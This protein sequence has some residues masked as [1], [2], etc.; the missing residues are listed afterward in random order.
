LTKKEIISEIEGRKLKLSNLD[1]CLYPD[2]GIVKAELIAYYLKVAPYILPFLR[3]RPL[4]LIR[5]PEGIEGHRFYSKN[6]PGWTP[7]WVESTQ[8]ST[9]DE[10]V[11]LLVNDV[12]SLIW[13]ANLAALELHPM[14]VSSR[15]PNRPDHF[16]F[17]LDPPESIDF[18]AVK[19]LAKRL[20]IFLE[21]YGYQP[22]LKTSGSKGLHIYVPIRS[23][24]EQ[25][26]VMECVKNLAKTYIETDKTTTLIMN[27]EKRQGKVLLDIYRNHKSQTCVAP[28]STR[29]K[30]GAPISAPLFWDEL[31]EIQTSQAYNIHT[32]FDKLDGR[33]DPWKKFRESETRLHTDNNI[34]AK[35]TRITKVDG[36]QEGDKFSFAHISL[37]PML[38]TLGQKAPS[39]EKYIFE[40]KWDGIRVIITKANSVVT[41]LSRNG[42]DLTDNFPIIREHISAQR[43]DSFIVDG[44]LVI[45]AEDGTPNF[46]K[47]VGRMH[48]KGRKAIHRS[49]QREKAAVYLF[50][51]LYFDGNDIRNLTIEKRRKWL[52]DNLHWG[53]HIKYSESFEDG[54]QLLAAIKAQ[55][56]EG[57]MCKLRGSKYESGQRSTSWIKVKV[58]KEDHALII[59]YT[60]GKGDRSQLFGALH[61]AKKEGNALVYLG[62]VGTGFSQGKIKEIMNLLAKIQSIKKPINEM[63]DDEENTIW[64]KPYYSCSLKY[65]SMSSNNTYREPVFLSIYK[66]EELP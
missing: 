30:K 65:A 17:D 7:D 49:S 50:D 20:K 12:P 16:I 59:G 27:K 33:G 34:E 11:Y 55:H 44:E 40:I 26:E 60:K 37:E 18:E 28:Y 32:I 42:N 31:D 2:S 14:H 19:Q 51:A 25:G 39:K 57:I 64:I 24:Y 29:G 3:D 41:I 4:T 23:L 46:S 8:L 15:N 52:Y 56:M 47:V 13:V 10:N 38:S 63:V 22:F 53:E 45:L 1:K 36:I 6:K 66:N 62:K 61:L 5:Y 58:K 54:E 21:S 9:D 43:V 48:K 35:E